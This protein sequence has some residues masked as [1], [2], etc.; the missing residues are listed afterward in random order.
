M[1]RI[2][3]TSPQAVGS[4]E[5]EAKERKCTKECEQC[6]EYADPVDNPRLNNQSNNVNKNRFHRVKRYNK[7]HP[8]GYYHTGVDILAS[9]GTPLKSMLCGIVVEARDTKGDLGIVVTVK[10]KDKD[11]IDIWIKYCHLQSFSVSKNT[12][13]MHG[14]IIGLTGNTGNARNI[15]SQYRH[16]HIEASRDGIFYGGKKRVD[17]EQFMKTKFDETKEGNV[18]LQEQ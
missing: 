15:L 10:S 2:I 7:K 17:I 3:I 8:K 1:A 16:I 18:I 14:E 13:V 12:K 9:V 11:G 5:I 6:F 4:V